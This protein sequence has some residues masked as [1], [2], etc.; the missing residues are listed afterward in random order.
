MAQDVGQRLLDDAKRRLADGGGD[1]GTVE[2][3]VDLRAQARGAGVVDESR[4]R[5]EL[6]SR[7][8]GDRLVRLAQ[9]G[10]RGAQVSERGGRDLLDVVQRDG[11][12]LGVVEMRRDARADVDGHEGVGERVVQLARDAQTLAGHSASAI[13]LAFARLALGPLALGDTQRATGADGVTE[14]ERH[15]HQRDAHRHAR[16][17]DEPIDEHDRGDDAERG[18]CPERQRTQSPTVE[19]GGVEHHEDQ[20]G[21]RPARAK[22]DDEQHRAGL[23]GQQRR[24]RRP[25]SPDERRRRR[26]REKHAAGRDAALRTQLP[27]DDQRHGARGGERNVAELRNRSGHREDA[28]PLGGSGH[29]PPGRPAATS[30]AVGAGGRTRS[31]LPLAAHCKCVRRADDSR[32]AGT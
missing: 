1:G 10:E 31:A 24:H 32:P 13:L 3:N 2:V 26:D 5:L 15:H 30:P 17:V 21:R 18:D 28:T 6:E 11:G 9:E 4:Q 16:E 22:G 8:G 23:D 7:R 20:A 25:R 29:R 12:I 14:R 19:R 27:L